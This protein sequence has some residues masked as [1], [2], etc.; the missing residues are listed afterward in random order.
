MAALH[1]D[2]SNGWRVVA[3]VE[4]IAYSDESQAEERPA[5]EQAL[6]DYAR[7]LPSAVRVRGVD[8]TEV[9]RAAVGA[10]QVLLGGEVEAANLRCTPMS[11]GA[12]YPS[13]ML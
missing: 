3:T 1:V 9:F 5:I 6:K 8:L 7:W 4:H 10:C 12:D 13:F 11:H 2:D